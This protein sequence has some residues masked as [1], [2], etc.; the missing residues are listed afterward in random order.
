[1]TNC[2]KCINDLSAFID[3]ETS[4]RQSET[5]KEH[6]EQCSRCQQRYEQLISVKSQ[7]RSLRR[8]R[9]SPAFM[10]VL[11]AHLRRELRHRFS[12]LA[13]INRFRMPAFAAGGL[14]LILLGAF[15][16]RMVF[17]PQQQISPTVLSR[18]SGALE[19]FMENRTITTPTA[20][21]SDSSASPKRVIYYVNADGQLQQI[22]ER[23]IVTINYRL[24]DQRSLSRTETPRT[25]EH[26]SNVQGI[27]R[28]AN[29]QT[30]KF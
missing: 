6:L 28:H 11:Y 4:P 14:L 30:V 26:V 23:Q 2:D 10:T 12:G 18:N 13:W 29:I 16:G 19:S 17:T 3:D 20:A 24:N 27:M 7:L 5:I 1:M 15:M 9:T 25:A 22:N 8:L 21:E